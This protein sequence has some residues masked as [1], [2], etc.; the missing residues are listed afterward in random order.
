MDMFVHPQ[1]CTDFHWKRQTLELSS[2]PRSNIDPCAKEG[3]ELSERKTTSGF[4]RTLLISKKPSKCGGDGNS[5]SVLTP[6]SPEHH[7][8]LKGAG[9]ARSSLPR[10]Q[11]H[12]VIYRVI[13]DLFSLNCNAIQVLGKDWNRK[14]EKKKGS[15]RERGGAKRK[16]KK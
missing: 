10:D 6:F 1:P 13:T 15:K 8:Q 7:E 2:A 12:L 5:S 9:K 3:E 14:K 11:S 4:S 16:I